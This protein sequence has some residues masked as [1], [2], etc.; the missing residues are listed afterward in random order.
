MSI[1]R[2]RRI[3]QRPLTVDVDSTAE[4]AADV[5]VAAQARQHLN[6][7]TAAP[8]QPLQGTHPLTF[9]AIDL[10]RKIGELTTPK[11]LNLARLSA[12]WATRRYFWTIN[13]PAH[14]GP[15]PFCLSTDARHMER[16]QKTLLSDEFGMGFA[17]LI[18]ERL[19]LVADFVD[20]DFAL[21]NPAQYFGATPLTERRP[22]FLMWGRRPPSIE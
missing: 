19:L 1:P 22:D 10:L 14:G 15:S 18:A 2:L 6:P 20:V 16:H 21:S 12:S 7:K 5:N 3:L 11:Q 4:M 13:D 8:Y 9:R 17:G